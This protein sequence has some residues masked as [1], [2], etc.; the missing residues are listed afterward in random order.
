[1]YRGELYHGTLKC[2]MVYNTV[3][4]YRGTNVPRY[5]RRAKYRGTLYRGTLYHGIYI[6][7]YI[8]LWVN[9]AMRF[10]YYIETRIS[11]GDWM[12]QNNYLKTLTANPKM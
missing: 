6:P 4:M 7:R 5:F 12:D 9:T 10:V 3:Q 1:M 11:C 8:F 2:T